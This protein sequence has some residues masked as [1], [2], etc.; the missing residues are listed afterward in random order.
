MFLKFGLRA[1]PPRRGSDYFVDCFCVDVCVSVCFV[2]F[3]VSY[4][5]CLF[6]VV[7]MIFLAVS[8]MG[9][10]LRGGLEKFSKAPSAMSLL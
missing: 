2:K 7:V 8:M 6:H 1:I 10:I 9:F 4:V 5:C 3:C